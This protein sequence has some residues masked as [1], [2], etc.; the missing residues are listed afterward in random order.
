MGLKQWL[1]A[2][3]CPMLIR[4]LSFST[5][6]FR[7]LKNSDMGFLCLSRT[8]KT[9]TCLNPWA[10]PAFPFVNCN[11]SPVSTAGA[12]LRLPSPSQL[13]C[14]A[15]TQPLCSPTSLP[16]LPGHPHVLSDKCPR[17]TDLSFQHLTSAPFVLHQVGL[18]RKL[19]GCC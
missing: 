3:C 1:K 10:R 16:P 14:S 2:T 15:I 11:T 6:A 4:V 17:A 9:R 12:E 8:K 18:W 7:E 19:V 13:L 5:Y